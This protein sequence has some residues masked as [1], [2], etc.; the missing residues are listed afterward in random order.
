MDGATLNTLDAMTHMKRGG[1]I[2]HLPMQML[3]LIV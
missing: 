2:H 1:N 3:D